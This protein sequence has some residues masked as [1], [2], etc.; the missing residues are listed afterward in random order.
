MIKQIPVSNKALQTFFAQKYLYDEYQ[1]L[2]N[3]LDTVGIG[4]LLG[5][6]WYWNPFDWYLKPLDT[7]GIG[8]PLIQLVFE[9]S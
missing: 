1:P 5:Y 8:T 2:L 9:T 7:V 3:P 4:N 6:S